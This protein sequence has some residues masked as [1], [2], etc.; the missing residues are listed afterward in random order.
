MKVQDV[1]TL[2]GS[3]IITIKSDA[4]IETL[5][6]L[7][8]EKRIGAVVVSNDGQTI[9]GVISERDVAYGL[10][11]HGDKLSQ[12]A[13][14][15]LMTTAVVTC[16]ATDDIAFVA[17]TMLSRN[18]RHLPV[19]SGKNLVGMVSIRDVLNF[20]VDELQQQTAQFRTFANQASR[21]LQDRE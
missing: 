13:T 17:S 4:T 9:D 3:A 19:V 11:V 14:S 8:R 20:R 10:A 1:L 5:S 6:R 7:L 2:K 12:L 18:I 15:A 16:G 21:P